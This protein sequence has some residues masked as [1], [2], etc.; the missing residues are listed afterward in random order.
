MRWS[1]QARDAGLL[2]DEHFTVDGTLLEAWA[3]PQ[4]LPAQ[5]CRPA[6]RRPTIPGNPDGQFPRRIAARTTRISRRP[7]PMRCSRARAQGKEAKLAYAGHVLLDNRHGL[8]ANV[9]VTAATGT[10][11]REAALLLLAERPGRR[12]PSAATKAFDVRQLR[13]RRARP[14]RHAARRAEG[15]GQRHRRP[16]DASC[17]ATRSANGNGS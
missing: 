5:G 2:S 4:E 10:A 16:D 12:R 9:C 15:Q 13:R 11:E 6:R 3:E 17:R 14:G 1:R 7:I 8:V